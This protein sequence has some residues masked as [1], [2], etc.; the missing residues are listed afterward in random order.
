MTE[1][2]DRP[3]GRDAVLIRRNRT[4]IRGHSC[5]RRSMTM[6]RASGS[7]SP[8][9]AGGG[10]GGGISSR[11]CSPSSRRRR[12]RAA[13]SMI[14][15]GGTRVMVVTP[16]ISREG[17]GGRAGRARWRSKLRPTRLA[18]TRRSLPWCRFREPAACFA[19]PRQADLRRLD[20]GTAHSAVDAPAIPSLISLLRFAALHSPHQETRASPVAARPSP[21]QRADASFRTPPGLRGSTSRRARRPR[22]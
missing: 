19:P 13:S 10:G 14:H 12:L 2:A 20:P 18:A 6:T 7:S 17:R 8:E 16:F 11:G 5:S 1:V 4:R 3:Q 15:G 21:R 9:R 22:P